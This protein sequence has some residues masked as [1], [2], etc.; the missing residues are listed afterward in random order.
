MGTGN[1]NE[2]FS[3]HDTRHKSEERASLI[4]PEQEKQ[5]FINVVILGVSF[6]LLF[7]AY[8]ATQNLQTNL[9]G[10]LGFESLSI[11]YFVFAFT[12]FISPYVVVLVGEKVALLFGCVCYCVFIA[13]NTKVIEPILLAASAIIGFGAAVLWTAQG[14]AVIRSSPPEKLGAYNG[15]FFGIFQWAQVL[16]NLLAGILLSKGISDKIL[17]LILTIIGST[18]L[19]GILFLRRPKTVSMSSEPFSTRI[20]QTFNVMFTKK[21]A[22]LYLAMI[23]SGVS[24]T[25]M[26]G[27]F[28]KTR[29]KKE[30]GYIMTAFGG[31][32]VAGSLL[33]GYIS[34]KVGRLPIIFVC[35]CSMT[36]GSVVFFLQE[37]EV[38][39]DATY[40][41]YV[42]SVLLGIADSGFNTQIYATLGHVF[43]DRVEAAIGAYKFF[44]AGS[45]AVLFLLGPYVSQL[46]YFIVV[47]ATLWSG[48]FLFFIL[49]LVTPKHKRADE[50]IN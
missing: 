29:P 3:G 43:P 48:T 40:L 35:A 37:V 24:Q 10:N 16:G 28:P 32:D 15:I 46:F 42:I 1:I 12:N 6:C 50:N 30:V 2:D 14:S 20:L 49:T 33:A 18:S 19:I 45:T 27:V 9:H 17:F 26:F 4:S 25:Y 34:D 13:A 38:L 7:I 36:A 21:M 39:G 5:G 47:L 23:Y 22:L 41:S 31:A 8:S 11:L 44:Q